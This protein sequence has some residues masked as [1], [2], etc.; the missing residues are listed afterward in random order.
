MENLARHMR[1][2]NMTVSDAEV[3]TRQAAVRNLSISW[4][5]DTKVSSIISTA[6]MI[7]DAL[8]GDGTSS[9][10][11]AEKV[12]QEIQKKSAS[13]LHDERPLDVGIC[14]A[15]AMVLM[16]NDLPCGNGWTTKDLY[17]VS[18]WL[19]LSYQ[20]VLDAVKRENLRRELLEVA[21][22]WSRSS[23]LKA[24]ERMKVP[25]PKNFTNS[26]NE[27]VDATKFSEAILPSINA[28]RFNAA[29]DREELDFLWWTH[30]AFSRLFRQP[31]T[32]IAEGPRILAAGIEGATLLRRFPCDVHREVILSTLDKN[33]KYDLSGLLAALDGHCNT[34]SSGVDQNTVM[35][36]PTVVPLLYAL[37]T[38][39][40]IGAGARQARNL[41]EWGE[42][43]LLEATLVRMI[44]NGAGKI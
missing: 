30:S 41:S 7:A 44:N 8:G 42:R 14:S 19:S 32:E 18:L 38:G 11:L 23:A 25:D 27:S 24:R 33:T 39:E 26:D 22:K 16:L 12:E 40:V 29:L 15:M 9:I 28:L 21:S 34:L 36:Y 1:I 5:K 13:Y 31:L 43:A 35:E 20:P 2:S 37:C 10:A 3:E 17:A 4:K 6:A